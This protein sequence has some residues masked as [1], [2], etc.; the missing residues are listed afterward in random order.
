MNIFI[1]VP[2]NQM[3]LTEESHIVPKDAPEMQNIF[4][5]PHPGGWSASENV[6]V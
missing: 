6:V 3:L 1:Y 4:K 2:V 5:D